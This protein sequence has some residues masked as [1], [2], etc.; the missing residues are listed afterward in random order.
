MISKTCHII[1]ARIDATRIV[2]SMKVGC[3]CGW[4]AV[5]EN[6]LLEDPF[7]AHLEI[8]IQQYHLRC[9]HFNVEVSSTHP[10]DTPMLIN[11]ISRP[12]E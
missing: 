8:V 7:E 9:E 6:P 12:P 10:F 5:M 3:I 4:I 1:A 11:G 2:E